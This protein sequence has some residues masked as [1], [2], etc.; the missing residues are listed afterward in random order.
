MI[1]ASWNPSSQ[2]F[3]PRTPGECF[4]LSPR[5]APFLAAILEPFTS[6]RR[7]PSFT[8]GWFMAPYE[9]RFL[10]EWRGGG[11]VPGPGEEVA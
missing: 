11:G 9:K 7:H 6:G 1:M 10:L 8:F 3:F 4:F 5:V 2:A